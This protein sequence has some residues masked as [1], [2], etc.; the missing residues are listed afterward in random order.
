MPVDRSSTICSYLGLNKQHGQLKLALSELLDQ[1]EKLTTDDK[2]VATST[3]EI[4]DK[5]SDNQTTIEQLTKELIHLK[6]NLETEIQMVKTAV[7]VKV[8][9]DL[10]APGPS[11]MMDICTNEKLLAKSSISHCSKSKHK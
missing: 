7:D 4:Q 6:Q 3:K 5:H 8:I 1:K 11:G 2:R 9:G 10:Y